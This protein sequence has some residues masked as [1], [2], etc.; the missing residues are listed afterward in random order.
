MHQFERSYVVAFRDCYRPAK[1]ES[2][3]EIASSTYRVVSV[4]QL[5]LAIRFHA[6]G[7]P[8]G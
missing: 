8:V 3:L 6:G 1:L 2:D 7:G 5:E 4:P